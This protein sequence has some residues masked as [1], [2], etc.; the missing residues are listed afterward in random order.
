MLA[1][2]IQDKIQQLAASLGYIVFAK[3][4]LSEPKVQRLFDSLGYVLVPK[5]RLSMGTVQLF[6]DSVGY[7]LVPKSRTWRLPGAVH[8]HRLF[9]L[10]RVDCV[11]DVGANLGQYRDFLRDDVGFAGLIVSFE[12]IPDH[13]RTLMERAKLDKNW[14]VESCALGS[15]TGEAQFNVMTNSQF[16]SFLSPDH[17]AV[18]LFE[19]QNQVQQRITVPVKTLDEV[20][21][22]IQRRFNCNCVYL[23]L[24]TQGYD[25]EVLKGA[26]RTLANVRA[27]QTEASV[28][29]IYK[30]MP[31]YTS[32][33]RALERLGFELSGMFPNNSGH[34]PRLIEFDAVMVKKNVVA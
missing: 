28:T 26:S 2:V 30:G 32:S 8:L 9:E 29:P 1:R 23:K 21:P 27:L 20:F 25:L 19:G 24:D 31:D 18:Q 6:D 16:S 17:S 5:S 7:F 4:H 13:V 33:I 12:P 3:W 10:L 22:E 11:L 14:I 34:F 15:G